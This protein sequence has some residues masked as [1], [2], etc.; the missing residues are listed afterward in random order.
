MCADTMSM[1]ESLPAFYAAEADA[2]ESEPLILANVDD[3]SSLTLE[4]KFVAALRLGLKRKR[5]ATDLGEVRSSCP[6]ATRHAC[7][8]SGPSLDAC[9]CDRST[10]RKSSRRR[11]PSRGA[12]AR[13]RTSMRARATRSRSPSLPRCSA[14]SSSARRMPTWPRCVRAKRVF[15]PRACSAQDSRGE[16]AAHP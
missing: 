7:R 16:A 15:S 8:L 13:C 11:P 5:E 12:S 6:N 14:S 3:S 1:I 10:M 9:A 2:S 4:A